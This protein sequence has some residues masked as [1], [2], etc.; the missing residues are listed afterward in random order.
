MEAFVEGLEPGFHGFHVHGIGLCE[1]E[2]ESPFT[3]SGGHFNPDGTT[4]GDHAG[5]L[6]SLLVMADGTAELMFATDR[7]T[8]EDLMDDDG[9]AVTIHSGRDNF[10][11]IPERYGAADDATLGA[12]DAG[13]RVGCGL[14]TTDMMEDM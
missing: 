9:A 10:A 6:P 7:F 11:N 1:T 5:D 2:I 8:I 14:V 13:S 4:H 3:T 12:G